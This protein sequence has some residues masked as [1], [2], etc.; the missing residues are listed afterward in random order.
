MGKC[1]GLPRLML[2]VFEKRF[3]PR[4]FWFSQTKFYWI[5]WVEEPIMKNNAANINWFAGTACGESAQPWAVKILF[6]SPSF[7]A[8]DLVPTS[9]RSFAQKPHWIKRIFSAPD[10]NI[11]LFTNYLLKCSFARMPTKHGLI[12]YG[13]SKIYAE[14]FF[15]PRAVPHT[16]GQCHVYIL[17]CLKIIS[18]SMA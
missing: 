14:I 10:G 4:A 2:K 3:G 5:F 18:C 16:Q 6:Y 1:F 15:M 12:I 9:T 11:Y 7:F 13:I 17:G 8:T